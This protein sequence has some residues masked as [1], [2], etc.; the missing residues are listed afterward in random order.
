MF[1]FF[2]GPRIPQDQV[3]IAKNELAGLMEKSKLLEQLSQSGALD[4]ARKITDNAQ[5]VNKASSSRLNQIEDNYGLIQSFIEQ[6]E[7]IE[8]TS[9]DSFQ[10]AKD[11]A[12]TSENGIKQLENL[13]NNISTSA[14]YISEFTELLTSLDENNKNIGLLVVSIK[15][16]A[17]QTNLLALNAAI[18]AARAGEH[19][20]GFAVVADEVRSLAN[21][22]NQSADK[23]QSEMKKIMDI[24]SLIINK[25]K[26]VS[27]IIDGSVDIANTTMQSLQELV[28]LS[29]SSSDLVGSTIEQVQHQLAGSETIKGNMQQLIDDTRNALAG[30]SENAA[31]GQELISH[32]MVK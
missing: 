28:T 14:Q 9:N 6:S 24:S 8:Q 4:I 1:N 32:L 27:T 18:E 26:D 3:L 10:S 29:V 7:S 11:T 16:I 2:S 23:I 30:S 19:G 22:A 21:T 31:L 20:R 5:K 25:Q 17:D 13:S 12:T 15:G